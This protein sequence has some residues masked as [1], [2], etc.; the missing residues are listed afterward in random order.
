MVSGARV[1]F[2]YIGTVVGA[3]FASGQEI[4]QFFT[5]YGIGGIWGIVVVL[6]L[7][8]WLGTRMMVM[9]ARLKARSYEVFNQ[10]LFGPRWGK[11]MNGFVGLYCLVLR[12]Q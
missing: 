1:G 7:F 2:T 10:Y 12:R 8:G 6:F 4:M 5:V 9:G 3:G 11:W